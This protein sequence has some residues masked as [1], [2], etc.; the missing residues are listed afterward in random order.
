MSKN[1][2]YELYMISE[3]ATISQND[4]I[5]NS[6]GEVVIKAVLQDLDVFNRNGR[7]YA[8]ETIKNAIMDANLIEL[9][10]NKTWFGEYG[11]PLSDSI[12]R[13]VTIDNKLISHEI[14][15]IWIEGNLVKA[16]IYSIPTRYGEEFK[17]LILR[18]TKVAFS[19]RA[20]GNIKQLGNGRVEVQAPMRVITY[21][22][23]ILPSHKI[24]YMEG[25]V[26]EST[27]INEQILSPEDGNRLFMVNESLDDARL[28]PVNVETFVKNNSENVKSVSEALGFAYESM[29]LIDE[30]T[31]VQLTS[32]SGDRLVIPLEEH[33]SKKV[34]DFLLETFM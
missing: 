9:M 33:V 25:I 20:V 22:C 1:M 19:L 12:T 4:I 2:Q 7:I 16:I 29:T 13:Q 8:N 17:K 23:V 18:G 15:K 5:E 34:D 10:N 21:D 28:L 27:G 31:K 11:H 30:G 3:A 14:R 6:N 26:N 24:A 32:I